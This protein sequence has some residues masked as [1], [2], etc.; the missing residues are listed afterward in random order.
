MDFNAFSSYESR[1]AG[2]GTKPQTIQ[3]WKSNKTV[4]MAEGPQKIIADLENAQ[5]K[6]A[7]AFGEEMRTAMAYAPQHAN[8]GGQEEAF[9]FGD[10]VD[11]INPLHHLPLVNM[12]YRGLTSDEI[13]PAA[14]IIG[15][16][17]YGGPI[18]AVS[19]TVNAITQMKTGK[20][21]GD[22]VMEFAG[23]N[24][25]FENDQNYEQIAARYEKVTLDSMPPRD[26]I[27]TISIDS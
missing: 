19:G 3:A 16:A 10:V 4:P 17:V 25:G 5:R 27:Q 14:Q 2:M 6:G 12:V 20:D 7:A 18:G 11:I 23:L 1:T 15:G 9:K 24:T 21:M 22:H 13:G 8:R 26:E